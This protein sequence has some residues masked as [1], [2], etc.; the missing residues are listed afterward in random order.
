MTDVLDTNKA[1]NETA[2]NRVIGTSP[3]ELDGVWEHIRIGQT[4]LG[5]VIT[6]AYLLA[7]GLI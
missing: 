5:N 7:T 6:D 3:V 2:L 4:N 1:E